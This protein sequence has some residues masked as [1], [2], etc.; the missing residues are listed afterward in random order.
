MQ[1]SQYSDNHWLWTMLAHG[2]KVGGWLP[3]LPLPVGWAGSAANAGFSPRPDYPHAHFRLPHFL[4]II[5]SKRELTFTFA[6]FERSPVRLS[7][8]CLSSVTFERPTHAVQ[9]FGNISTALDTA[10]IYWH[11]WHTLKISRSS[12]QGNP[13][14]GGVKHKRGRQI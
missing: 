9:I 14:A 5:F 11:I 2:H 1:S 8:V 13:S 3:A 10:D 7:V 12:S 4:R 6:I